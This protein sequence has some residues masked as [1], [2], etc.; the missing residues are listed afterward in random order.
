MHCEKETEKEN[1]SRAKLGCVREKKEEEAL[2]FFLFLEGEKE[3]YSVGR[4]RRR[5]ELEL[6]DV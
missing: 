5:G 4:K 3:E 6:E 2:Q 1:G